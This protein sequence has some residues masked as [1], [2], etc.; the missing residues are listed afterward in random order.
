MKKD[1]SC[2]REQSQDFNLEL[3]RAQPRLVERQCFTGLLFGNLPLGIFVILAQTG[4][5]GISVGN[6]KVTIMP[7]GNVYNLV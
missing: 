3:C 7:R 1:I 4:C 5:V 2:Q 6:A